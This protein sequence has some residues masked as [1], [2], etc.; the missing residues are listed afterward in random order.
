MGRFPQPVDR[1]LPGLIK[2][3]DN[4]LKLVEHQANNPVAVGTQLARTGLQG[5]TTLATWSFETGTESWTSTNATIAQSAAWYSDGNYCLG[6]TST[7]GGAW[8]ATTPEQTVT[9]G[10]IINAVSDVNAPADLSGVEMVLTFFN[11]SNV[12]VGDPYIGTVNAMSA[13]GVTSTELYLIT[14]PSGASYCLL[15]V[16]D[17][18]AS[19]S[20]TILNVDNVRLW[21]FSGIQGIVDAT[22]I[23]GA[24]LIV[25]ETP[26]SGGFFVY[27]GTPSG[28]NPPVTWLVGSGFDPYGT[29]VG[30]IAGFGSPAGSHVLIDSSGNFGIHNTAGN[31]IDFFYTG[32]AS[33]RFYNSSGVGTGN[34]AVTISPVSGTDSASNSYVQ[35]VAVYGTSGSYIQITDSGGIATLALSGGLAAEQNPGRIATGVQGTSPAQ[36]ENLQMLGPQLQ[37]PY[38]D[39]AWIGMQS[40]YANGSVYAGASLI[41]SDRSLGVHVILTWGEGGLICDYA[42]MTAAQP[43]AVLT[44]ENWHYVGT[45]GQPAFAADWGNYGHGTNG[46]AFKLLAEYGQVALNG[47]ITPNPATTAPVFT[48]PAGYIPASTQLITGFNIT[49][50]GAGACFLEIQAGTGVV[51]FGGMS[52]TAL[53]GYA[54]TGIF[55][56]N[57]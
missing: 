28:T 24:T 25:E 35:G 46:M 53:S 19:P 9:P 11:S 45:S 4:R 37:S 23:I 1:R 16:G 31:L 56:L 55:S 3:I 49:A 39:F 48:L 30:A 38:E 52:Q 32:D 44:Q 50:P 33:L 10:N 54:F 15:S 43:G 41:Y 13:G 7:G 22:T 57:I 20:G 17:S 51:S 26:S 36:Y 5:S 42:Q 21:I 47:F 2:N 40:S 29:N 34:L 14:V 6:I 8:S 18:A 27:D 12:Q